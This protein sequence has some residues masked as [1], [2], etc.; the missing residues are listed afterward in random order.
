MQTQTTVG[1]I[2]QVIGDGN[3]IQPLVWK[4]IQLRILLE[5]NARG[6]FMHDL[7]DD[8]VLDRDLVLL[9]DQSLSDLGYDRLPENLLHR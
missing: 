8:R 5:L 2:R 3:A 6:F 4:R 7:T 9:I 1:H